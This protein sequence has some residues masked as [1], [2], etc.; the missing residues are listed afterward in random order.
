M[1]ITDVI[2]KTPEEK[3]DWGVNDVMPGSDGLRI[4]VIFE[5]K[6]LVEIRLWARLVEIWTRARPVQLW[7]K[8]CATRLLGQ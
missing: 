5:K 4:L 3:W 1:T 6:H 8:G 2:I 7:S